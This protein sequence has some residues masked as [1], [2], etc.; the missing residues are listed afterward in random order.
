VF[1]AAL[2]DKRVVGAIMLDGPAF[3]TLRSKA[4]RLANRLRNPLGLLASGLR[5]VQRMFTGK[6]KPAFHDDSGEAFFPG[7]PT[8]EQMSQALKEFAARNLHLL[9]V[10][11]GEWQLYQYQGQLR[12]AFPDAAFESVIT[13]RRIASADHLYFT[14]AERA[15]LFDV[16]M[17]WLHDHFA[18]PASVGR[19]GAQRSLAGI[20]GD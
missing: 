17:T 10:N 14:S 9:Y 15:T 11:S 20:A 5:R 12:D 13:E 3:P 8:R 18:R 19:G 4:L 2:A 6:P 1:H 7:D 16:V